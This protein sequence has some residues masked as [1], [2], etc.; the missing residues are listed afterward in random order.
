MFLTSLTF[1]GGVGE[2]G[3]NKI[4]LRDHDTTILLDF[5]MSFKQHGKYF[6]EFL[7]ARKCNCLEDMFITGLLP[8]M[9]GAYR[10]DYLRHSG[11]GKE[12]RSIDA[13]LLSHA[14]MDHAAYIHHLRSDIPLWM[15]STTKAL[16][17]TI[18][19]TGS[20]SFN[21]YLY[22]VPSFE[23]VPK[24]RDPGYRKATK[25]DG[26]IERPVN[27]FENGRDFKIDSITVKPLAVDHSVPGATSFI[28]NTSESTI[29]YTGD[30][31]FHGYESEK[32][33]AM[34]ETAS[35][36]DVDVVVTEGTRITQS[37]GTS[38]ED[39]LSNATRIIGGTNG[40]AVVNYP[41]RDLARFRT[42]YRIAKETGRKLVIDFKQAY[43]LDQVAASGN[44]PRPDDPNILVYADRKGWGTAGR[45]TIPSNVAGMCIPSEL[46]DQDYDTWEK[47]YLN[48]ENCVCYENLGDQSEIMFY[49]NYFQLTEL[50]DVKP[51]PGSVY[52]RSMT[53]PFDVEMELD[54]KRIDNWLDLF[55]LKQY[56]RKT[57]DGLHASGHASGTEIIEMLRTI[58][59]KRI[60][61]IH[62]EHPTH[63]SKEFTG[64]TIAQL[65]E[66]IEL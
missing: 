47:E 53:E 62:T 32:T 36:N 29:L 49:C 50:I 40:L 24:S 60:I 16:L 35:E 25:K 39:V 26:V 34:V 27:V 20:G 61:P 9:K 41:S 14:H 58:H 45:N 63:L 15:S 17:S 2:I 28:I 3:G 13:V 56:G 59:P 19:E 57:E 43:L 37:N 44:Y 30:F 5:G 33:K 23:L 22:L 4:V 52:L 55:S 65:G 6:S 12:D 18:Q 8:K 31:R 38:E 66:T 42:F 54:A 11:Y 46:C 48:R 64:V 21:D 51:S 10:E 1:L 7:E